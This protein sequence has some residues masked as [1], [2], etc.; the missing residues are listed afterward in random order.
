MSLG[1]A[2]AFSILLKNPQIVNGCVFLSPSIRENPLHYPLLKKMTFLLSLAMP[3]KQLMKQTGRNGSKYALCH[4]SK[5]D[6]YLY[7]GRL[8]PKT[9]R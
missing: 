2:V 9:V 1:G 4:Y 5:T 7:H 8:Y 6:P 3:Y